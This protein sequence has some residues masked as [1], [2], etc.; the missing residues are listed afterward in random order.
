[1]SKFYVLVEGHGEV[2]AVQNLLT[3]VSQD[4]QCFTPWSKP[5][6]WQNIHQ[7]ETGKGGVRKGADFIRAKH[8][9]AGLLILCDEDD[10]CPKE[11]APR[12]ATTL[13]Q[14][15]LPFPTAYVLLHPEGQPSPMELAQ[16]T[17]V[18]V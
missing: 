8:D 7:W 13:Q 18:L 9:V 14:M 10:A 15:A 16:P 12:M 17:Q 3:R 4:A 1:M 2:L 5:L 6:R 11:L